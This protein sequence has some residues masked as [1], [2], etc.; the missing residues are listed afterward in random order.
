MPTGYLADAFDLLNVQ[1]LDLIAQV[2]DECDRVL[3]GVFTDDYAQRVTG[4]RPVVPLSERLAL[5]SHLRGVDG[6]SVHEP[7]LALVPADVRIFTTTEHLPAEG[8]GWVLLTP[9]R[10]TQ[11]PILRHA[12]GRSRKEPAA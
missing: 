1:D 8:R 4:R 7:G 9:R 12:L 2:R 10:E 5:L 6:A 3:V 11:A